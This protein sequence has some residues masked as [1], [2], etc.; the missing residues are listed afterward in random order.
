MG[1]PM[2]STTIPPNLGEDKYPIGRFILHRART[3]GLSRSDLNSRLGFRDTGSG[4][5]ALSAMLLKG[6]VDADLANHL[7][8]ALEVDA[9]LVRSI[10]GATMRQKSDEARLDRTLWKLKDAIAGQKHRLR[11]ESERA[12]VAAFRPHLQ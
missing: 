8:G 4:H 1:R 9:T 12:Y 7:A 10:I 6:L 11:V 3:L 2:G 5:E